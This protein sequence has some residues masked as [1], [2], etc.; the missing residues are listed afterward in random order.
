MK[1][2]MV[3][4]GICAVLVTALPMEAGAL[5]V[6]EGAGRQNQFAASLDPAYLIAGSIMEGFGIAGSLE[7]AVSSWFSLRLAGSYLSS[8][9]ALI[10][11]APSTW[12]ARAGA[13]ARIYPW[14]N[15]LDGF[16]LSGGVV[17]T[18]LGTQASIDPAL[19]AGLH[20]SVYV[21]VVSFT[22]GM[23]YKI[24]LGNR[25]TAFFIEPSLFYAFAMPS[26]FDSILASEE[27]DMGGLDPAYFIKM[28]LG[29]N[30]WGLGLSFGITF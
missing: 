7:Y 4:L 3:A 5:P 1:K 30:G 18:S 13:E 9:E 27:G 2:A 10:E 15:G 16:Y 25:V 6:D 19:M 17:Y 12:L 14:A 11:E 26:A 24:C 22:A 28:L 21:D 8:G 23:G 29:I 20:A